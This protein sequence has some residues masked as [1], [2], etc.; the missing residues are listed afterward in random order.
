MAV[1]PWRGELPAWAAFATVAGDLAYR[2]LGTPTSCL[3]RGEAREAHEATLQVL[4]HP[5][6]ESCPPCPTEHEL[7]EGPS[8]WWWIFGGTDG[9][10][11]LIAQLL[12]WCGQAFRRV[13]VRRPARSRFS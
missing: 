8:A 13:E 2:R 10:A 7:P 11:A 4:Q 3:T 12:Q 1:R 9:W 5:R 6:A